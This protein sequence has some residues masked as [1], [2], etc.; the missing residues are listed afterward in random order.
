M[1]P[2]A[3]D[4]SDPRDDGSLALYSVVASGAGR[5]DVDQ[6]DELGDAFALTDDHVLVR[7]QLGRSR[8][9]HSVKWMLPDG[10]PVFAAELADDPKMKGQ[11][12]GA[13]AW[14]RDRPDP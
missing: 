9:Y 11:A 8:L 6:L 13:V 7:T 10:T 5:L 2:D 4:E 12:P 3:Q 1:Q 14:V